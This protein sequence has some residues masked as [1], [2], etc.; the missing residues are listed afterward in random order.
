[1]VTVSVVVYV[2]IQIMHTIVDTQ[3][4]LLRKRDT[5][6]HPVCWLRVPMG[7]LLCSAP[8]TMTE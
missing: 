8:H 4:V 3:T 7:L 6:C 2:K 1:M 5:G